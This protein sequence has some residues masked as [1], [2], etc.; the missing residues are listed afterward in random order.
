MN[1]VMRISGAVCIAALLTQG[2]MA[3]DSGAAFARSAQI[4]YGDLDL[5]SAQG[6]EML[7]ERIDA[8]ADR[9]C[10]SNPVFDRDYNHVRRFLRADY[11]Q[12]RAAVQAEAAAALQHRGI[13][14]AA[15]E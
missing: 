10:G 3:G 6:L 13:R 7:R 1:R 12:C 11:G 4:P 8:A 14:F 2:A 15:A 5:N 9:A